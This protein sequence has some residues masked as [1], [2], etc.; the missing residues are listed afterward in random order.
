[1]ARRRRAWEAL[2]VGEGDDASEV[3]AAA[4]GLPRW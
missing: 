4:I 2:V 1:M 3:T